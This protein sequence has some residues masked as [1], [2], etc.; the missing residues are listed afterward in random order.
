MDLGSPRAAGLPNAITLE[1]PHPNPLPQ[2]ERE[3]LGS[4]TGAA[5]GGPPTRGGGY[6]DRLDSGRGR[7]LAARGG[8]AG[9]AA[10]AGCD[11]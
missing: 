1:T 10:A 7:A 3:Y 6:P 11:G 8:T 5:H 9:G 4:K 2:G